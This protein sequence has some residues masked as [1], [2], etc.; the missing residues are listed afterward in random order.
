MKFSDSLSGWGFMTAW[1][2][3]RLLPEATVKFA[4]P[5]IGQRIYQKNGAGVV[6]LRTNLARVVPASELPETVAAGINSYVRYWAEAFRLPSW[7]NTRIEDAVQVVDFD[8]FTAAAAKNRGVVLALPHLGNYDLAGAWLTL[9]GYPIMSVAER[10]Q[11]EVVYEEFLKYREQIG[12][13]ILP[14]TGGTDTTQQLLAWLQAGKIVALVSDRDLSKSAVEVDFFGEKAKFPVGAAVLAQR[15]QAPLVPIGCYYRDDKLVLKFFPEIS[16]AEGR[17]GVTQATQALA[18][19][20]A[21]IIRAHP[22][23]WH[24]LQRVFLADLEAK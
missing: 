17:T 9:N 13:K 4:I 16:V 10:L 8:K 2:V 18:D 22:Q 23:D 15:A 24:M 20:F 11:P 7:S 12:I 21:E 19:S 6:R 1:R 5:K 3:L 14:L